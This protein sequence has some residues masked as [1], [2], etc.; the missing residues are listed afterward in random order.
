M[1]LTRERI[2]ELRDKSQYPDTR[3]MAKMLL[4]EMDK[5][6]V[7]DKAPPD[8]T[9]ASVNYCPER[10]KPYKL[11]DKHYFFYRELPKTRAREIAEECVHEHINK[12]TLDRSLADI[13]ESAIL[14]DREEREAGR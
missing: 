10:G 2:E 5:P 12:E 11:A 9:F 7:W 8:A 6:G 3:T 4:A 14:K 13:I 1:E